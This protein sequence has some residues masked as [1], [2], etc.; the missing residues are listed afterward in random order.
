[1]C[2][3]MI[4]IRRP[5]RREAMESCGSLV[6]LPPLKCGRCD[7]CC[8]EKRSDLRGRGIAEAEDC[9]A[10]HMVTLTYAPK[11]KDS[12]GDEVEMPSLDYK[13]VQLM[14]YRIRKAGY[15]V[16][17]LVTGEYGEQKGRAHWHI[18]FFWQNEPP[19]MEPETE[20]WNFKYWPHGYAYVK[21]HVGS[22][23]GYCVSYALKP[24][25][26]GNEIVPVRM[27][28]KPCLGWKF[29]ERRA[30]GYVEQGLSPQN[31]VYTLE[32]SKLKHP[33]KGQPPYWQ[34][35]M[36][37]AC[38]THFVDAF[39]DLWEYRWRGREYPHSPWLERQLSMIDKKKQRQYE[40]TKAGMAEVFE[41]RLV[42]ARER[43][44]RI[45]AAKGEYIRKA[46]DEARSAWLDV[47]EAVTLGSADAIDRLRRELWEVDCKIDRALALAGDYPDL[48][49]S[50]LAELMRERAGVEE[51]HQQELMSRKF[52]ISCEVRAERTGAKKG[53]VAAARA[54]ERELKNAR[55]EAELDPA[56]AWR[57]PSM[58][59]PKPQAEPLE[60][61]VRSS[62]FDVRKARRTKGPPR[63]LPVKPTRV[64]PG[65]Y[66]GGL[67]EPTNREKRARELATPPRRDPQGRRIFYGSDGKPVDYE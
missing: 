65:L 52:A 22:A 55:F 9:V 14:L 51:R 40:K 37:G 23:V 38:L 35:R 42:L 67:L 46:K 61:R 8:D 60:K 47:E 58:R 33:P 30:V 48:F 19:L 41:K 50:R 10:F 64:G 20:Y 29:F 21:T 11:G 24:Q 62:S 17:Y 27:S 26:P 49:E 32:A 56:R 6:P 43:Q 2:T 45:D 3:N 36:Y 13:H 44:A 16:R 7:K 34:Y 53:P 4:E 15:K 66:Q 5:H 59:A 1:M 31:S 57:P 25:G 12:N 39:V 54:R 63:K 18:C 28:L